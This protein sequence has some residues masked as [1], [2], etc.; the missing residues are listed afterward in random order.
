MVS[1]HP[2]QITGWEEALDQIRND[3]DALTRGL[4]P[5]QFNWRP[6]PDKWSVGECFD[7]LAIATGLMLSRVRPVIDRGQVKGIMGTPPFRY[8]IMGG[9]FVRMMATPPAPGKRSMPSPKNFVPPSGMP[10]PEV[11]ARY[12]SVLAD[13]Q[14]ALERSH[15]LALDK[16][17]ARSAGQGGTWLQF[18]L[19]AWFAATIAHLRRHLAQAH[20][21]TET[22]GFPGR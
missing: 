1:P 15:G 22:A 12:H 10:K 21:V 11:M 7:H 2:N 14:L 5:A 18:N 8:G 20:R 6:A 16:L 19:A 4:N 3:S 9:W 13:L 17:R